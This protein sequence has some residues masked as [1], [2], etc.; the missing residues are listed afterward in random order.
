VVQ[1]SNDSAQASFG[2]AKARTDDPD[3]TGDNDGTR[4]TYSRDDLVAAV[5]DTGID[6]NH[7][8]LDERKVLAFKDFVNGQSAPYDD[9]G[10]GTHVAGTLAGDGDGDP[11]YRGV[12]PDAGLVGVKVLNKNGSGRMSD[13]TAGI[14]WTVLNR[15]LYGIEALNLSLGT[16][17]CSDGT[18]ATSTAVNRAH[19][20]GLVA[21]VAA[22]NSGP[23]TCTIGTPG[24][25][26]NAL[27]VGAMADLEQ[28]GF[29][30][31]YFSSRGKTADGRIKPDVSAPGVAVTSAAKGTA[32][33]YAVH[34]GT[35]MASPFVAGV[36]LLMRDAD[37][38][39][40]SAS[41]KAKVSGVAGVSGTA[42]DWG[43]GGDNRSA[44]S[45][46]ADIDYGGGR[47]DAY[48]ALKSAG[49]AALTSGPPCLGTSCMREASRQR[50]LRRTM[51][52]P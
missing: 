19:N 12:A 44:G 46:G 38:A 23:G 42:V 39:L 30:Q 13:I 37:P 51:R 6:A 7:R 4:A 15:A 40:T 36:A 21:A 5:I 41:L 34:S 52:S 43:R 9:D 1:A 35:S 18:D 3:L 10:H 45:S 48:A 29:K 2:V 24:A 28:A 17:G 20:A 50:A 8:D 31:A 22:G 32:T 26:A 14:D 11:R 16:T 27:T 33:G 47:L 25:A 49:A